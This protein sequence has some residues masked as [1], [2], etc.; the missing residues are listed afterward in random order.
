MTQNGSRHRWARRLTAA[1]GISQTVVGLQALFMPHGFYKDF[2]L[3]R[4]WVA[5]SPGYSS[6]L[7]TD[8]GALYIATGVLLLT[9]A[10]LA[11]T[12]LL[13]IAAVTTLTFAVPHLIF[14]LAHLGVYKTA[15]AVANVVSL[16]LVALVPL[17]VLWLV[18]A[19][20]AV[21]RSAA[22]PAG[23]TNGRLAH[24][25]AKGLI[26]R[27][28]YFE[29]K[30][31]LGTIADPIGV[32]AHHPRVLAGY[33]AF[34]YALMHSH[35]VDEKLKELAVGKT[36]SM[37]GCEWCMDFGSSL[38]REQ[39]YTDAHLQALSDHTASDLFSDDEKLVCDY[40][41]A[42]T[43]TPARIPDEL[44][45][46][47]RA[48]FDEAQLVE[49]TALIAMENYRARFNWAFGIAGQGF[50]E[51]AACIRAAQAPPSAVGAAV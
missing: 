19:P 14:H 45:E 26:V 25:P 29:T 24:A 17:A 35:T 36:A 38:L 32:T 15:D 13:R 31:Q 34:E 6:H 11:G 21:V 50:S 3:G 47:L 5:A 43:Q 12:R 46:R 18:R 51:G 33:G 2:P 9:A 10:W 22:Y 28:S 42:M 48:K 1:V 27:G 41:V 44:F 39:G 40:A 23:G 16:S 49:L 8:F 20:A 7:V 30:R 37:V 4:G